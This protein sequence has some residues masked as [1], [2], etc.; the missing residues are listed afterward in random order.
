MQTLASQTSQAKSPL[1]GEATQ[2]ISIQIG[3][4]SLLKHE[5]C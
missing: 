2:N 1:Y 3:K 5:I 4:I